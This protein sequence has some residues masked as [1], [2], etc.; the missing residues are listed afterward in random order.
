M[1]FAEVPP[2]RPNIDC[3]ELTSRTGK[4]YHEIYAPHQSNCNSFYQCSDHG[5]VELKCL[6][7]LV[8]FPF[9]NGEFDILYFIFC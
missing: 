2:A 5:L 1:T 6:K 9:I 4:G 7:G 8:F 3:D